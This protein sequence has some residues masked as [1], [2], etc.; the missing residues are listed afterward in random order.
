MTTAIAFLNLLFAATIPVTHIAG[1][2]AGGGAL[3]LAWPHRRALLREPVVAAIALMLVYLAVR[4]AASAEP[5]VGWGAVYGF[6][7]HWLLPLVLGFLAGRAVPAVTPRLITVM[8]AGFMALFAVT[9]VAYAG[10]MPGIVAVPGL[11]EFVFVESGLFK[12]L[13][14]HIALA[15]LCLTLIFV[16]AHL[17]AR[18]R[19]RF[20]L[21]VIGVCVVV[22]VL[23][24]S[25]GYYIAAAVS[26]AA[27][28]LWYAI[29]RRK[30]KQL[31]TG[32]IL[33][34]AVAALTYVA[35]PALNSRVNETGPR[36][37]N[38]R[39]RL[40]LYSVAV[41]EIKDRP[42]TGFGPG[43]GIRQA[44]YFTRLEPDMRGVGRHPHLHSF[45]L[46]LAADT[47]A[48]GFVLFAAVVLLLL[49][50]LWQAGTGAHSW[51]G[52]LARGLFWAFVGVLVGDCFDTLLLG[53]RVAME[54][55]WLAGLALGCTAAGKERS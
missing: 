7:G 20:S 13:H 43:Q 37:N 41:N 42:L 19:G 31:F 9:F 6:V 36:D 22:L 27:F 51:A 4:T 8:S 30:F 33:V 24:G 49:R 15:A 52:A 28:G 53:P 26:G 46:N 32:F 2:A 17:W 38:V 3:A 18:T 35:V 25:R 34:A 16:H 47:G 44:A 14:S 5:A 29:A 54:L 23:T 55:F 10:L 45:Y 21:A 40:A 11:G 48:I 12:G 1:Y 39:E 50:R